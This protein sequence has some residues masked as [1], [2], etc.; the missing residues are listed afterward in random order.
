ML[1]ISSNFAEALDFLSYLKI[2]GFTLSAFKVE[3]LKTEIGQDSLK[4]CTR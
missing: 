1:G 2:L 4:M 3:E